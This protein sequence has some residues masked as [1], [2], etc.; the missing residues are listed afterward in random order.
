MSKIRNQTKLAKLIQSIDIY[1]DSVQLQIEGGETFNSKK[2]GIV[3]LFV[4]LLLLSYAA[5]KA[6]I[7][8]YRKD[9]NHQRSQYQLDE[10]IVYSNGVNDIDFAVTVTEFSRPI[11]WTAL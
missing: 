4:I 1:G 5:F 6:E 10:S 8:I 11:P 3:T 9:T 7:M 2:G